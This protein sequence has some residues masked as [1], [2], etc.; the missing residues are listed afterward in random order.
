[1]AKIKNTAIPNNYGEGYKQEV[2]MDDNTTYKIENTPIPNNYGGGYQKEITSSNG[3][4]YRIRNTA[5]PNNYGEGYKQEVYEVNTSSNSNRT[6]F[7]LKNIKQIIFSILLIIWIAV[8]PI[9]FLTNTF[10][11]LM[12]DF[13]KD[14]FVIMIFAWPIILFLLAS[15][16]GEL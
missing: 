12:N 5:I 11:I 4:K 7:N 2:I 14:H 15:G 3:K 16:A 6:S 8:I 9:M 10:N 1:M 13:V